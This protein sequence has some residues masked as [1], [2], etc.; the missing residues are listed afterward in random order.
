MMGVNPGVEGVVQAK[1]REPRFKPKINGGILVPPK[2]K[3]VKKMMWECIIHSISSCF[4]SEATT[5]LPVQHSNCKNKKRNQI[6]PVL[7][8]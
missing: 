4:Q 2:R 6:S 8:S 5:N 3:L 7:P 1:G